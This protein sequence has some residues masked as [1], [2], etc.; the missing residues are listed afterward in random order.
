MR[1]AIYLA[2]IEA[3]NAAKIG[4][5]HISLWNENTVALEEQN[6]F[7]TPA[8]FVEFAPIQW[9]QRAQRVKAARARINLHI[10]TE[11]LADPSDG[12]KFQAQA[13]ETFDTID[14]IVATVQ[15]LS[16]EG[17]NKFL[18]VESVPDHNHE[19]LQHDIEGFVFEL[20]DT[21]AVRKR[22]AVMIEKAVRGGTA[23]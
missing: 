13:L 6:G 2:I 21:G 19:Q 18:H 16:G 9:E 10:V 22:A 17:F 12:S 23:E 8:V 20:T 4:V 1:K 5:L 11:T 7:A 3:I 15:G 14:D